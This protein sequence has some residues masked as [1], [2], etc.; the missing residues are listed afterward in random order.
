[1]AINPNT[2]FTA[3]QVLTAAQMN[4]FPRGIV[5]YAERVSNFGCTTSEQVAITASTFTAVANR[6]YKITYFE[7][8]ANPIPGAGNSI[9]TKIRLTNASGTIYQTTNRQESGA[10][11]VTNPLMAETVETFAAGS[12]VIVGTAIAN[13]STPTLFAGATQ[14]AFILV[15]DIG[16]A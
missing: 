5:A 11:S 15:E 14:P 12:V 2:D 3:G 1:M 9:T 4:R 13:T 10:T 7:P 8:G 6:Y 16:P